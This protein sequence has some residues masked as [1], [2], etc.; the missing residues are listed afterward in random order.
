MKAIFTGKVVYVKETR[1]AVNAHNYTLMFEDR[2][3]NIFVWTRSL[4]SHASVPQFGSTHSLEGEVELITELTGGRKL[5]R[6]TRC[7][8]FSGV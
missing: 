5:T 1:G 4:K 8:P 7:K 6:V 2:E 3:G